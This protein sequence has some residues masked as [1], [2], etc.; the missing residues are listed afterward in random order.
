MICKECL[1]SSSKVLKN[2]CEDKECS[3][4][5]SL[6]PLLTPQS[7]YNSVSCRMSNKQFWMKLFTDRTGNWNLFASFSFPLN[8]KKYLIVIWHCLVCSTENFLRHEELVQRERQAWPSRQKAGRTLLSHWWAFNNNNSN[9]ILVLLP[10][11]HVSSF[12]FFKKLTSEDYFKND[13]PNF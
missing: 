8:K 6:V 7:C 3:V 10:Y 4:I 11:F 13:V 5:V 9:F 1:L 2:Y 12:R